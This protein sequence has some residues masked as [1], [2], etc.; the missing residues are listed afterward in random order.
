[1]LQWLQKKAWSEIWTSLMLTAGTILPV[2]LAERVFEYAFE[3]EEIPAN[4]EVKEIIMV[5]V[6]DWMDEEDK[7]RLDITGP[8]PYEAY[9]QQ[10]CC[11]RVRRGD[12]ES[13]VFTRTGKPRECNSR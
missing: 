9:K 11:C 10:Y 12:P 13:V 7:E 2:E 8:R 6:P 5:D 4:P 3:E 1:M